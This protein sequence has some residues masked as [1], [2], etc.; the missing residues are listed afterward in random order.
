[1]KENKNRSTNEMIAAIAILRRR[2]ELG[3]KLARQMMQPTKAA[4]ETT[5]VQPHI[6][7]NSL[8]PLPQLRFPIQALWISN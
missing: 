8:M 3:L 2:S 5:V 7:G 6:L 1:M 4:P